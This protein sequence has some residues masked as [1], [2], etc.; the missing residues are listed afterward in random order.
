MR[1]LAE[2]QE[3]S[4][5]CQ[6]MEACEPEDRS[7]DDLLEYCE[8][9]RKIYLKSFDKTQ[10]LVEVCENGEWSLCSPFH[11]LSCTV[12][13]GVR[14]YNL[15]EKFLLEIEDKAEVLRAS[16]SLKPQ[17]GEDVVTTFAAII[18]EKS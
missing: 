17:Y 18:V 3:G 5:V 2:Y 12:L 15:S 6:Y 8:E 13:L 10:T 9:S 4:Y 14:T 16:L 1:E 11:Q 7:Y